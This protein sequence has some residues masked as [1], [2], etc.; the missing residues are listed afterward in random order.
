[1]YLTPAVRTIRDDPTDDVQATLLVRVPDGITPEVVAA[2]VDD[3]GR[4]VG[5]TQFGDA[6]VRVPEPEV[7]AVID[8]LPESVKA[9]ETDAVTGVTGDTGEDL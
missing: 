1:M 4:Y 6:R 8:A 2:A 5:E 7:A 9:V 3:H